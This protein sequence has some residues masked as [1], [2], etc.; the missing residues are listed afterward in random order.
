ML[1][2]TTRFLWLLAVASLVLAVVVLSDRLRDA[3]TAAAEM[4][5]EFASL[6][7]E[8]SVLRAQLVDQLNGVL[9]SASLPSSELVGRR[10]IYVTVDHNC[11]A[12]A[13]ALEKL[14]SAEFSFH[15]LLASDNMPDERRH[16]WADRFQGRGA[17]VDFS[18]S[19]PVLSRIPQGVTPVFVEVS[20]GEVVDL[21]IGQPREEW[22][23]AVETG[24]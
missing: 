18:T 3:R 15:L 7:A 16:Y 10:V 14:A 12:S 4:A 1:E 23:R 9:S 5:V 2:R 20:D 13:M 19:H 6:S 11:A 17:W 22:L 8:T 24:A 21:V